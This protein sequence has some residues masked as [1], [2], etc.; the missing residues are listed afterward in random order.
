MTN[1]Y[2]NDISVL[3]H[4]FHIAE[5]GGIYNSSKKTIPISTAFPKSVMTSTYFVHCVWYFE[6]K[7][8]QSLTAAISLST[9]YKT[10]GYCSSKKDFL[11]LRSWNATTGKT[12]QEIFECKLYSDRLPVIHVLEENR[13]FSITIHGEYRWKDKNVEAVC[14]F[15]SKGKFFLHFVQFQVSLR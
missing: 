12:L 14:L 9:I 13:R 3:C 1:E 2:K 11:L 6:L 7:D 4:F 10:Y 8:L 15:S 5:C